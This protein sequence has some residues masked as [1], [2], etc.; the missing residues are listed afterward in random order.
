MKNDYISNIEQKMKYTV[1]HY[2]DLDIQVRK[3]NKKNMKT[4]NR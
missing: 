2:I 1:E 3:K 4:F